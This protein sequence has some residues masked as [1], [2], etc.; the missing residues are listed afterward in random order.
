MR[1]NEL[2]V[3]FDPEF[4][5]DLEE[6]GNSIVLSDYSI[7]DLREESI[8]D[9]TEVLNSEYLYVYSEKI[10]T[11]GYWDSDLME[12]KT[13]ISLP[14]TPVTVYSNKVTEDGTM[15]ESDVKSGNINIGDGLVRII[16]FNYIKKDSSRTAFIVTGD[17]NYSRTSGRLIIDPIRINQ[18]KIIITV[19]FPETTK[20]NIKAATIEKDT[21]FL[22]GYG[23]LRGCNVFKDYNF[24]TLGTRESTIEYI[25]YTT[26]QT[27][28]EK[29]EVPY[30][31]QDGRGIFR[32]DNIRIYTRVSIYCSNLMT[33]IRPKTRAALNKN[34]G[35][36]KI[37]GT[38][39]YTEYEALGDELVYVGEGTEAL[40]GI[41]D[42][43]L[44]LTS[45][46]GGLRDA[47]V[48]GSYILYGRYERQTDPSVLVKAVVK[49]WNPF[50]NQVETIESENIR[51]TQDDNVISQWE[52]I[53]RSSQYLE[54]TNGENL[55]VYVFP[56]KE[57]GVH[58]FTVRTTL[59]N[60]NIERD[61]YMEYEDSVLS[62]LFDYRI[63]KVRNRTYPITDYK[64]TIIS[65]TSN[66]NTLKWLPIINGEST[67][68]LASLVL[69]DYGFYE[70]FYFV[71]SPKIGTIE[72][73]DSNNQNLSEIILEYNQTS[74]EYYPVASEAVEPSEIGD[75]NTWKVIDYAG[76]ISFDFTSGRINPNS[77]EYLDNKL[78]LQA[79]ES[80]ESISD[81]DIG[82]IVLG[83]IRES[84]VG[85]DFLDVTE[86]RNIINLSKVSIPII[87][88]GTIETISSDDSIT[89]KEINLYKIKIVCNGP[90]ACWMNES[91]DYCFFNPRTN[92]PT[93]S[94]H[95]YSSTFNNVDGVYVWI[96]LHNTT[97]LNEEPELVGKAFF[98]VTGTEPDWGD[99][100]IPSIFS[101]ES[102]LATCDI[103]KQ[104]PH[105]IILDY[106][107]PKDCYVFLN[108]YEETA[109][110]FKSTETPSIDRLTIIDSVVNRQF[111]AARYYSYNPITL[112]NSPTPEFTTTEQY[113]YHVQLIQ[114]PNDLYDYYPISPCCIYRAHSYNY[115][116][117][118]KEFYIFRKALSPSFY[119][120]DNSTGNVIY[121]NSNPDNNLSDRRRALVIRSRYD[122][123]YDEF[124]IDFDVPN[125]FEIESITHTI[126]STSDYKH[127][128]SIVLNALETNTGGQR[129][130][131][132]LVITSR[133]YNLINF[134]SYNSFELPYEN[135][136]QEDIDSI[137][138][139]A[140][141][142]IQIIQEAGNGGN[143]GEIIVT[144]NRKSEVSNNGE[145]RSFTI[146]SE[147]LINLPEIDNVLNC[148]I[149]WVSTG[150]FTFKVDSILDDYKPVTPSENN[151]YIQYSSGRKLGFDLLITTVDQAYQPYSESFTF[152]QIGINTG[153]IFGTQNNSPK[154]YLGSNNINEEV[155]YNTTSLNILLGIFK[156]DNQIAEGT[157]GV[158]KGLDITVD[159][160]TPGSTYNILS[161]N[162]IY[163]NNDW[164]PNIRLEFP[165]N[166]T[167]KQIN[168]IFTITYTV[169]GITHKIILTIKQ[170]SGSGN[171]MCSDNAYFLSHGECIETD[172]YTDNLGFFT[173]NTDLDIK[174]L[175]LNIP[176][177]I[178]EEY[179]FIY[180][181]PSSL[182]GS[183]KTYKAYIKLRPNLSNS[184]INNQ[185]F[186]FVKNGTEIVKNVRINQGFY[187]LTI[188]EPKSTVTGIYSGGTLGSESNPI[189]IP[190][191]NNLTLGPRTVFK[192]I[193][194]R[195][196]PIPSTGEYTDE[197]LNFSDDVYFPEILN[198]S[199]VFTNISTK[200]KG[201][202]E[203]L[204]GN[205]FS[206]ENELA[207]NSS[208]NIIDKETGSSGYFNYYS[209]SLFQEDLDIDPQFCPFLENIYSVYS[210]Y[211][212][213]DIGII[214][215][216]SIIVQY[217]YTD[218][219]Y[220]LKKTT[221]HTYTFYLS[222][223]GETD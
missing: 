52:V 14:T 4:L 81:L 179:N 101:D 210:R 126:L 154:L 186:S 214:V 90:F 83:R 183:Y 96:A 168:R 221:T 22:E 135:L 112:L 128:Y 21:E 39:W 151:S 169:S 217:P 190:S 1:E 67:L 40:D 136:T 72:L 100:D 187:C 166:T 16:R 125:G 172:D 146:T 139:P 76:D 51:I 86:W 129:S 64:V 13:H 204:R 215:D 163:Y 38:L 200:S 195:G 111:E 46:I 28:I 7:E 153:L 171:V 44:V 89:L 118:T 71:Q 144:G 127:Q 99:G 85:N 56:W 48:N 207:V 117:I 160:N 194:R 208:S 116:D 130:L 102:N 53:Y 97:A 69:R 167:N 5:E 95:Y 82:K 36:I 165:E 158:I 191:R 159:T 175:T 142:K 143:T 68:K 91:S 35:T 223:W 184:K 193:L 209:T 42:S 24:D 23:I 148:N 106:V 9:I 121:V 31:G 162:C 149:T 192:L 107:D 178:G 63:E 60:I 66:L 98:T 43:E 115:S 150:G 78:I 93:Y 12:F 196:E 11:V 58:T 132:T 47:R 65:K 84:E 212:N 182:G 19:R 73:H 6:L 37:Y 161:E 10:P 62:D 177:S 124:T 15:L 41:S 211:Y 104:A 145:T 113:R 185:I 80:P 180:V 18:D 137:V 133:I 173:F 164:T 20:A 34:G 70:S 156:L 79:S 131:G 109:L 30:V 170:T 25:D 222:K 110:R 155:S 213:S 32:R 50:T 203:D 189:I 77:S 202:E 188:C 218:P 134:T 87:K 75:R 122:I 94:N 55:P 141:M 17:I 147:N 140:V 220:M 152:R 49:F 27:R 123:D 26:S 216:T 59:P 197:S 33:S 88:R 105:E 108:S 119:R 219:L 157:I 181:G 54:P 92:K 176:R 201:E 205:Q 103:Y 174:T 206:G 2:Y 114:N 61:F 120:S 45:H 199:W 74:G 198:Y 138:P 3:V 8:T 29:K 57:G